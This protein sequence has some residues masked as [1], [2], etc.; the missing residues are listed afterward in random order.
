[1]VN[2]V[3]T[4]PADPSERETSMP[5][6][7]TAETTCNISGQ[8]PN[9][10]VDT[11]VTVFASAATGVQLPFPTGIW[12]VEPGEIS[13]TMWFNPTS[14]IATKSTIAAFFNIITIYRDIHPGS[15]VAMTIALAAGGQVLNFAFPSGALPAPVDASDLSKVLISPI[16]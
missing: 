4:D 7:G 3:Y 6:A 15:G 5:Y 10:D 12:S 1:M 8:P 14:W 2:E 16:L 9:Y 13:V 11:S